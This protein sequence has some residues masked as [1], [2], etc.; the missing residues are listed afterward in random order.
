MDMKQVVA[1]AQ[2]AP[3]PGGMAGDKTAQAVELLKQAISLLSGEEQTE[4]QGK[5]AGFE[6]VDQGM[7]G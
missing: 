2:G 1:G 5:Q 4:D 6:S 3:M 7:M